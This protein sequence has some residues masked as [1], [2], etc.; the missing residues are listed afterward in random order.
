MSVLGKQSWSDNYKILTVPEDRS[1]PVN[2]PLFR[3][4]IMLWIVGALILLPVYFIKLP[5]NMN[6][7]DI[8]IIGGLPIFWLFFLLWRQTISTSYMLAFGLI[9]VGSFASIY[10]APEPVR[11]LIVTFKGIYLFVW[12]LTFAALFSR[13]NDKDL[14]RIMI[15]WCCVVVL[16]G[17]LIVAQ[18]LSPDFWKISSSIAGHPSQ[19]DFYRPSGMF[20]CEDAGCANKAA[21]FQLL[22]FVPLLMAGLSKRLT[23]V[24]G[25]FLLASMLATGS[26]GAT[27][28][29]GAGLVISIFAILVFGKISADNL[30]IFVLILVAISLFG[31]LIYSIASQNERFQEHIQRILLG[32]AERS[33]GGRFELWQDGID[34]LLENN[35][36]LW[37]VG[38]ENF[39]EI[40]AKGKQLHNDV[41]A[42]VVERGLIGLLGLVLF[43]GIAVGRAFYL[44]LIRSKSLQPSRLMVVVFLAATVAIV[45]ESITHQI[46]HARQIWLVL[47]LQEAMLYKSM[48][49]KRGIKPTSLLQHNRLSG[50]DH[51]SIVS[52]DVLS[53]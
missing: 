44:F 48:N 30:K 10:I 5:S 21:F 38:P 26:M 35:I 11:G 32:R 50:S 34:H 9:L 20:I 51:I 14:R 53:G 46:F 22:S 17:C 24:L 39:R 6:L 1:D 42:F 4:I 23:V 31:G 47:A 25:I 52:H 41:L 3:H 49:S 18:F 36:P 33:S 27:I 19:Y 45:V 15:V 28:A 8:W 7:V 29:F 40:G 13:L 37:G 16:H 43:G 12:F 2:S